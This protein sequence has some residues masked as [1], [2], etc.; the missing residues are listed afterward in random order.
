M[1]INVSIFIVVNAGM[2]T[3]NSKIISRVVFKTVISKNV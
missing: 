3:I 2:S 1:F